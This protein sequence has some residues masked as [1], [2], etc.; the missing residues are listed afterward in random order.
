MLGKQQKIRAKLIN[1]E[2][3]N[4]DLENIPQKK[5]TKWF[6]YDKIKGSI[7]IRTRKP[8]DYLT[9]NAMNQKK[10]LKAYFIDNKIPQQERD[11]INLVTDG[12]HVMW[13]VGERISN[14]YKVGE[15][16][17]TI[18]TLTYE[19]DVSWWGAE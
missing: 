2:K 4:I 17:R 13:I 6:D 1:L 14:Y 12:N 11:Q 16:T 8:G 3:D 15:D 18:L 9:V 5:Y 19:E 7:V 10:T